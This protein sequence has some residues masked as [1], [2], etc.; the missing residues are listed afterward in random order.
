MLKIDQK[1][2]GIE[3]EFDYAVNVTPR[4]SDGEEAHVT[5]IK[6]NDPLEIRE[7]LEGL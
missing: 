2:E 4:L 7:E 3:D 5:T 1:M 6:V